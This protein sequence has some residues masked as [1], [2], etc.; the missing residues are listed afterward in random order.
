[1]Y[2]GSESYGSYGSSHMALRVYERIMSRPIFLR[3]VEGPRVPP[4]QVRSW[5]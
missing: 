1:M 4:E 3:I 2:C 5:T